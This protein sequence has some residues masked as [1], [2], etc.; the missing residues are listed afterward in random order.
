V[1]YA[2]FGGQ[3][4]K[5]RRKNAFHAAAIERSKGQRPVSLEPFRHLEPSPA[6]GSGSK[7]RLTNLQ[8]LNVD[9]SWYLRYRAATNPDFG[10]TF[11]QAVT[12]TNQPVIP[13]SDA[14]TPPNMSA[15]VPLPRDAAHQRMQAIANSAGFHFAMIE[16]G[17]LESVREPGD[18]GDE[19]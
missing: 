4:S 7:K 17:R 14:E 19:P 9:T 16:Q 3:A 15:P 18:E 11:G 1:Q 2:G 12:I 10:A 6:T 5:E 8:R 13:L